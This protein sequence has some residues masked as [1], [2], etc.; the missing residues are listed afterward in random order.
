MN[1]RLL[2]SVFLSLFL[3]F[4]LG[5]K[6]K[7]INRDSFL[8]DLDYL[9]QMGKE[10]YC[11]WDL[12]R[13]RD[14][15]D[16]DTLYRQAKKEMMTVE[17]E[18]EY[19]TVLLRMI[20]RVHDGHV[21]VY[22]SNPLIDIYYYMPLSFTEVEG[23]KIVVSFVSRT[24]LLEPA[25]IQ[26]G[27]ELV[28]IDGQSVETIIR[29]NM[30]MVS[31][32]TARMRRRKAVNALN[33]WFFFDRL[34]EK[35][36]RLTLRKLA[37]N[38]LYNIEVPWL[39]YNNGV[40]PSLKDRKVEYDIREDVEAR[41]LPGNIGYLRVSAM[42]TD[43]IPMEEYIAY[44]RTQLEF[45]LNTDG[46]VIDVR[47]NGG[48][49]G[50]VGDV[51]VS[52]LINQPVVLNR[53]SPRL[54]KALLIERPGYFGWY[55]LISY[56]S[57]FSLWK[58][59]IIEPVSEELRYKGKVVTLINAGCFSACD[60]FAD[61][62]AS[63]HL[64][65]IA[66]EAT[67]GGSGAPLGITMPSEKTTARFSVLRRTSSLGRYIE[68]S[69]TRPHVP[70]KPTQEDIALQRDTVL[71]LARRLALPRQVTLSKSMESESDEIFPRAQKPALPYFIEELELIKLSNHE[72][73]GLAP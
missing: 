3:I 29:R 11:Y 1:S 35:N 43:F 56:N 9:Y 21:G 28:A 5:G 16:W 68:G 47:D 19:Y 55:E 26:L 40:D 10:I 31:G 17:T 52:Y 60:I 50:S 71:E 23:D 49:Y 38:E 46:L 27:D 18:A 63:N 73:D 72:G 12:K 44:I 51:I 42:M 37:T 65:I 33:D 25:S 39:I 58:E 8:N 67:G 66:G 7:A 30:E 64:S 2:K 61:S 45:L 14:G 70:A 57:E 32:S 48:G 13:D 53:T 36:P 22:V 59:N 4:C 15:V 54:S 62:L 41:V 6:A 24:K 69:G 34:P 20:S